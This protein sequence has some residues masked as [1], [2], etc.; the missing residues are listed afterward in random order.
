MDTLEKIIPQAKERLA[1][2]TEV[3]TSL[4]ISGDLEGVELTEIESDER[5]MTKK[6]SVLLHTMKVFDDAIKKAKERPKGAIEHKKKNK[7]KGPPTVGKKNE[8]R[9]KPRRLGMLPI[10]RYDAK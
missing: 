8:V 2:F 1:M 10:R 9:K 4:R 7:R 6:K 3:A 5:W